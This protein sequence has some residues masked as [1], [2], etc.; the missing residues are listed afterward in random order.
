MELERGRNK[1]G[2]DDEGTVYKVWKKRWNRRKSIQARK[3]RDPMPRMQDREE[4]TIVELGSGSTPKRGKSA[5][6]WHM[7][8]DSKKQSKEEVS[9]R[10]VRKMFKMLREV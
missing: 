1:E 6:E 8:R 10:D 7:D 4:E 5:V 9:Q 3:K 2:R